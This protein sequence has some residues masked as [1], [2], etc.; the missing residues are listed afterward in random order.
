MLVYLVLI[1]GF[2]LVSRFVEEVTVRLIA[3]IV[4]VT[5]L[6]WVTISFAGVFK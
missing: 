6:L 3:Q 1:V 2:I 5:A 4:P